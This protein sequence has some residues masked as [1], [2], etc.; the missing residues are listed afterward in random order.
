[1]D[2]R[3]TSKS[4]RP[5]HNR[6]HGLGDFT[7]FFEKESSGA[8]VM[9]IATIIALVAANTNLYPSLQYLWSVEAGIVSGSFK[10]VQSYQHW[11]D[12]ALMTI[13]F[14]VVG[15][16]IKREIIVGELSS[17]R[18]AILPIAAGI[19]GM[20]IPAIIYTA[21][22]YGGPGAH[23]WGIPMATDLAFALGLLAL[24]SSR[25]PRTLKIF[26]SALAIVDDIA[27]IIVIALFYSSQIYSGWLLFALVPVVIM[28]IMNRMDVDASWP[29]LVCALVLWFAFLNSGIHATLAGIIAAFL[30]PTKSAVNPLVFARFARIRSAQVEGAHDPEAATI[31]DDVEQHAAFDIARVARKTAAPL[32]RLEKAFLPVSTFIVLPIFALVNAEIHFIGSDI[33]PFG[34]IGMGI[35]LGL[36][37]GKPLGIFVASWVVL[38]LKVTQL[39]EGMTLKHLFG[40]SM[41]AGIGFTMSIFITNLAFK[42]PGAE[43]MVVEAK[44]A[45][46]IASFVAGLLGYLYLRFIASKD[47]KSVSST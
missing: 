34:S 46:L 28:I 47:T 30:I 32:Q 21:I 38:K 37:I 36:V 27:S 33:S 44:L 15:L 39:P 4:K 8:I 45:I 2:S 6:S 5:V 17:L 19:G 23:G 13:F 24:L 10:F 31:K 16:E 3:N 20:A 41:L 7:N 35:I 22:N 25:V 40:G 29:Y 14:F 1:M 12:D 9:L 43:N 18:E 42:G 11:V 26:I